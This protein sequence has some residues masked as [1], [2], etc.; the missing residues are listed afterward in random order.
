MAVT[1]E[2]ILIELNRIKES[3]DRHKETVDRWRAKIE[4]RQDKLSHTLYGNGEAGL[5]ERVRE[6]DKF[7]AGFAEINKSIQPMIAFYKV[8]LWLASAL[9]FSIIALIW[10]LI[11]GQVGLV[12]R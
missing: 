6:H 10:G 5:D 11:T 9:G 4:G 7:I 8:G 3:Q 12:F 1:N 2:E